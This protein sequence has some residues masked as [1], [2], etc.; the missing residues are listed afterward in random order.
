M[1]ICCNV[2]YCSSLKYSSTSFVN[3]RV[4]MKLNIGKLYG[5][6][7]HRQNLVWHYP[8]QSGHGLRTKGPRVGCASNRSRAG[9]A[10]NRMQFNELEMVT[11]D[12]IEPSIREFSRQLT[13]CFGLRKP[14]TGAGAKRVVELAPSRPSGDR[15]GASFRGAAGAGETGNLAN[16][17]TCRMGWFGTARRAENNPEQS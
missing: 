1:R 12:G 6:A 4:S 9:D 11:R 14:K 16:V 15:T 7:V 3:S 17:T 8:A 5:F 2:P 13:A 10:R